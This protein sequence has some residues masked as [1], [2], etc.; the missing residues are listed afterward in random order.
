MDSKYIC[1]C[2]D[3]ETSGLCPKYPTQDISKYPYITQLSFILYDSKE[4]T[5]IRHFNSYIKQTVEHDYTSTAFQM[6]KI[7]KEMCDNGVPIAKALAEFYNC[8]L[9]CGTL[10]AHN[11]QFDKKMIQLEMLRNYNLERQKPEMSVMFND[12]FNELF[13]IKTYCTM[14]GGKDITSI[15]ITDKHGN[16]WKKNPKLSELYE[17]L[18]SEKPEN[19]HNSLV[20]TIVCLKCYIKMKYDQNP[21][22]VL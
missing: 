6:T 15:F 4:G 9:L 10:V 8:Y 1:L 18:F 19:L 11:L 13:S 17:K 12:T 3:T 22:I 20:D 14:N 7:T 16:R 21:A 2:F 5:V